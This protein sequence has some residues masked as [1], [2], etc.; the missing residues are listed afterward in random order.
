MTA[1]LSFVSWR[2][3]SATLELVRTSSCF[4]CWRKGR[5]RLVIL[6]LLVA[7][8]NRRFLHDRSSSA[9]ANASFITSLRP[10]RRS[11]PCGVAVR[12]H[13]PSNCHGRGSTGS[14]LTSGLTTVHRPFVSLHG[15]PITLLITS[16][17]SAAIVWLRV[18]PGH[19]F[20]RADKALCTVVSQAKPSACQHLCAER[21]EFLMWS[22]AMQTLRWCPSVSPFLTSGWDVSFVLHQAK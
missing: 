11:A 2:L 19:S 8:K 22:L 20:K 13:T 16:L 15:I 3:G 18:S 21:D 7:I 1:S 12:L 6:A 9:F 5:V 4:L 10:S 17:P 14:T